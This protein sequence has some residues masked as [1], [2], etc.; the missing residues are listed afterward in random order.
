MLC[1]SSIYLV[2][3]LMVVLF[4]FI[5]IAASIAGVAK[6]LSLIFLGLFLIALVMGGSN[7][8]RMKG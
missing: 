5:N 2:I 1:W 7:I 3:V 6:I 4:K 8:K